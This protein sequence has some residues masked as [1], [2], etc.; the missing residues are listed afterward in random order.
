M[1][2]HGWI[3]LVNP[4]MDMTWSLYET[5][6]E[7]IKDIPSQIDDDWEHERLDFALGEDLQDYCGLHGIVAYVRTNQK[8]E[9]IARLGKHLLSGDFVLCGQLN[10]EAIPLHTQAQAYEIMEWFVNK[11]GQWDAIY[12]ERYDGETAQDAEA[13]QVDTGSGS[14]QRRAR[15]RLH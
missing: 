10:G 5:R 6:R 8:S 7:G 2:L 12:S 15:P 14:S 13:S 1:N 9:G 4:V 3:V 11:Q